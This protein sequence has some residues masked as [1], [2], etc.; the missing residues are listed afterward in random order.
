MMCSVIF[1]KFD[2][3]YYLIDGLQQLNNS[4]IQNQTDADC[5]VVVEN[6]V[7]SNFDEFLTEAVAQAW[8]LVTSLRKTKTGI[9]GVLLLIN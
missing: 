3:L 7:Y 1:Q 6:R 2:S 9:L 8:K 5:L 4:L